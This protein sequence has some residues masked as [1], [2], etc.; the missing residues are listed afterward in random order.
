MKRTLIAAAVALL[1][2]AA[3]GG[4]EPAGALA[5][6]V[7]VDMVDLAFQPATLKAEP[8]ERIRFVFHNKGKQVHD[9]FIGDSAAQAEHE[10]E[11]RQA[12]D[13]GHG[14]GHASDDR[15]RDALTLGPGKKGE[16]TYTFDRAGTVEV[17]CHQPG[18]YAAG[19]K[20]AVTVA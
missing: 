11:M 17:G 1:L 16:L 9:A 13:G 12:K 8:G 6:S 4:D 14:G 15:D 19:M 18:H 2:T 3:C 7:E 20:L 10:K 5:R